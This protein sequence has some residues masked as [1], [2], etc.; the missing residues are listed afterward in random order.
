M[1]NQADKPAVKD[2][3]V[4][5][6]LPSYSMYQSTFYGELD[7]PQYG[8]PVDDVQSTSNASSDFTAHSTRQSTA[9]TT[10]NSRQGS[11]TAVPSDPD[12]FIVADESSNSWRETV[13]DN[14]HN[15]RNL[16]YTDNK[17]AQNVQIEVFFTEEVGESGKEPKLI[18]PL[19]FEYKQGDFLNGYVYIRNTGSFDITFDMFYVLF[20]GTFLVVPGNK[21]RHAVPVK[22]KKFLEMYD[23]AASWNELS[24]NRLLSEN[25]WESN[26]SCPHLVDPRDG[27][28]LGMRN[29]CLEPGKLYKRF[30]TFKIPEKLLDSECNDHNLAGHTELPPSLGISAR[31]RLDWSIPEGPINDFS[32]MD[33]ATDYGVLARF[34]GKALKYNVD[35]EKELGTR[36]INAKGDEFIILKD[37]C[38]WVRV[39]QESL[40]LT[41]AEK[42]V[43]NEASRVLYQNFVNRV[44]EKIKIGKELMKAIKDCDDKK[45][46]DISTR[47][48]AEEAVLLS[49]QHD[50][51]IKARQLYTRFD[52]TCKNI[53]QRP[54][55]PQTHDLII[56]VQ[57]S[58]M[59]GHS[60]IQGTLQIS[61]P[62]TEYLLSYM[63]PHRFRY[64]QPVDND[65]WKLQ[66]PVEL[67]FTPSSMNGGKAP[68]ITGMVCEL[69]VFTAK[70]NKRPIPVELNHDFLFK[71][72]PRELKGML[73]TDTFTSLVKKPMQAYCKELY[74]LTQD[75]GVENFRL[76]KSLVEDLS[77]MAHIEEKYN[78][79]SL[80]ESK[81]QLDDGKIMDVKKGM[82]LSLD[83]SQG[84][85]YTKK[86]SIMVDA[87]KA[88]KKV[89]NAP[90]LK[91]GYRSFDHFTLVPSFQTC[92]VSRMYY[93]R[94]IFTL[95]TGPLYELKLPVVI[96][97]MP[98]N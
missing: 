87:S 80:R 60:K 47:Q 59:F 94:I 15:L 91:A 1:S 40:I 13:L 49:G 88:Q 43:N 14:I 95:S 51:S 73:S 32:F 9:G 44:N 54:C 58:S 78:N 57:K 42:A 67:S 69:V 7:P 55:K 24:V 86:F 61:S 3:P 81:I 89:P 21:G 48:A 30:F 38:S 77:A 68:E 10:F 22:M 34:I 28:F 70:S 19:N 29:R 83:E 82:R 26:T 76:E 37:S 39:L 16:T 8:E 85:R 41:E 96:A 97:K 17:H 66:I 98:T 4:W 64:G 50:D 79:L 33:T 90:A 71:N 53:G 72:D 35:D 65:V 27:S 6:I 25:T 11:L 2:D 18:D 92:L 93:L 45:T 62:K 23:F 31:E 56:P 12:S 84:N 5:T 20:E 52:G 36:L 63:S 74:N 75:L 46:L